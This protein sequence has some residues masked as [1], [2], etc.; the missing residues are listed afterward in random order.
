MSEDNVETPADQ[1]SAG[2]SPQAEK[3]FTQAQ[4]DKIISNRLP[5]FES[6]K[7]KA[8]QFDAL[9]ASA[10]TAE[11]QQAEWKA[12]AEAADSEIA[13]RDTLL[14]RQEVAASKGLDPRLWGRVRG[15]TKEEIEADIGELQGFSAPPAKRQATSLKSGASNDQQTTAKE[16]AAQ[17]LRGAR[18][19]R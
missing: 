12:K 18:E 14:L 5:E 7:A 2:E 10:Q 1:A 4:L 8:A 17:A 19:A 3:T 9:T 16:R 13:W 15:E 11:E 6:Y